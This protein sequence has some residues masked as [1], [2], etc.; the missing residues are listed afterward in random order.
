MQQQE[1]DRK[2]AVAAVLVMELQPAMAPVI[3]SVKPS[4]TVHVAAA[5]VMLERLP[6]VLLH[7][8]RC[9]MLVVTLGEWLPQKERVKAVLVWWQ[10]MWLVMVPALV[11]SVFCHAMCQ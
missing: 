2:Q 11:V 3:A 9:T 5:V 1:Q 8:C 10:Q 7:L 6:Q 4:V